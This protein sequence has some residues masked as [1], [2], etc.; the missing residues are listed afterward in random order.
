[1]RR[2]YIFDQDT[3][4]MVPIEEYRG[5]QRQANQAPSVIPDEMD[6]TWHPATGEIMTS[7]RKFRQMT[8]DSGCIEV[9]DQMPYMEKLAEQRKER[10]ERGEITSERELHQDVERAI[11]EYNRR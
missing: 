7:K 1:M 5:K 6:P 9:G 2:T 4:K 3:Q 10:F 8:K 11:D